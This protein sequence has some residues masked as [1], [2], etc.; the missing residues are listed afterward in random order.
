M[1]LL[2]GFVL[3]FDER[4]TT[5]NEKKEV[6]NERVKRKKNRNAMRGRIV[7]VFDKN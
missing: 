2:F 1:V 4:E 7:G 5:N 3:R 6:K